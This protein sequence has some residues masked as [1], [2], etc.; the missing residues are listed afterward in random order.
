VMIQADMNADSLPKAIDALWQ[1]KDLLVQRL[2]ALD[3]ADGTQAV[4]AQIHKYAKA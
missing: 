3:D 4:L 1:D 2:S